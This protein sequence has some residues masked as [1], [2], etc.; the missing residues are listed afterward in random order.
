MARIT[1]RHKNGRIGLQDVAGCTGK[2][3]TVWMCNLHGK[4]A[5]RKVLIANSGRPDRSV[6]VCVGCPEMEE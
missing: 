2:R 5:R 4:A 1:C 3:T 6:S